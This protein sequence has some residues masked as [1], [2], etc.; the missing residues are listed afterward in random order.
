MP[1]ENWYEYN[2]VFEKKRATDNLELLP[3]I[4]RNILMKMN[5][6]L[7]INTLEQLTGII[8]I[9]GDPWFRG[10][11]A[12]VYNRGSNLD[13]HVDFNWHT[14]LK[15]DRRLNA[16]LYLND[17]WKDEWNGHLELWDKEMKNCVV[18]VSPKFN[19]LVIFETTDTSFHGLPEPLECPENIRRKSMAIYY[20]SNGRPESEKSEQH[21]TMFQKRPTDKTTPE[22]EELRKLRNKGR[23]NVTK[24]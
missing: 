18:K 16:L 22:I 13:V 5:S 21:S 2:N 17:R 3:E 15:L 1:N 10:G 11:G 6:H 14:H 9:I 23:L 12:H 4:H 8:G 20:Y 7:F 24:N 19:R